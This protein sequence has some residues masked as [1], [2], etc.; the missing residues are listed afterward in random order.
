MIDFLL[1]MGEQLNEQFEL[2]PVV[3][4]SNNFKINGINVFLVP[5]GIKIKGK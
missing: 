5:D 3:P 1:L 2:K 4:N